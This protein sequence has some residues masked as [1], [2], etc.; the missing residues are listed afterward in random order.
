M[1]CSIITVATSHYF[2]YIAIP[3]SHLLKNENHNELYRP[4]SVISSY[5]IWMNESS[6]KIYTKLQT[7]FTQLVNRLIITLKLK[8]N[9]TFLVRDNRVL[10]GPL[11]RSLC[12]FARTAHSAHSLH[13]A[14]LRY[15]RFARSLRSR[16]R[17]LTSL[18]PSWDS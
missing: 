2:S 11:G 15:T 10:N 12:L 14:S 16:A 8:T 17:S 9:G 18:T 4:Q 6:L 7:Q 3:V 1:Y 13:S 5:K